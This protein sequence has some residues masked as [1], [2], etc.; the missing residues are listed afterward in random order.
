MPRERGQNPV[1]SGE[2]FHQYGRY[3]GEVGTAPGTGHV[4]VPGPGQHRVH[5]VAHLVEEVLQLGVGEEGGAVPGRR[6]QAQ[7]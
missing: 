3:L 6:R 1:V 7:H 4:L 5:G 2:V